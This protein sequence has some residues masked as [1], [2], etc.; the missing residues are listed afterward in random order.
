MTGRVG[1]SRLRKGIIL[2]SAHPTSA[3]TIAFRTRWP[4][5]LAV[6]R[7]FPAWCFDVKVVALVGAALLCGAAFAGQ[8]S[9]VVFRDA[10][11]RAPLLGVAVTAAYCRVEN[12]GETAAALVRFDA[13][14]GDNVRVEVHGTLRVADDDGMEMV[15]MRP[16]QGIDIEAGSTVELAPGGRHLMVFNAPEAGDLALQ[17]SF[18]DGS[19]ADVLFERRAEGSK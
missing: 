4:V 13:A 10:W 9:A 15:R 1:S 2:P 5:S 18:A 19:V 3:C 6:W 12:R 8:A 11:Y 14:A 7:G 16:L 17:A